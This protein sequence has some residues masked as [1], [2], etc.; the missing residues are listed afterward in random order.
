MTEIIDVLVTDETQALEFEFKGQDI[1]LIAKADLFKLIKAFMT[2]KE[3]RTY[4]Q[5]QFG[6]LQLPP[7]T[8]HSKPLE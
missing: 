2:D 7:N 6:T 3:F 5:K 8:D 1:F 4:F